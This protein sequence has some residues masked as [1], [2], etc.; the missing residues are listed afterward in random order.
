MDGRRVMVVEDEVGLALEL[1]SLLEE[2]GA[3]VEGPFALLTS[4]QDA[5]ARGGAFDA[6]IVDLRLRDAES[7]PL[8]AVLAERGVPMVIYTG[9]PDAV[10]AYLSARSV[11]ICLKP[12]P[13]AQA[14][15]MVAELMV[16]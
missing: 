6:A 2:A 16:A 9:T 3:A 12:A 15:T 1:Q 14:V 10:E 5:L 4:A 8:I 11:G 13:P 7:T